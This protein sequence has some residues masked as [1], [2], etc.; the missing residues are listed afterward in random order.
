[1]NKLALLINASPGGSSGNCAHL[2]QLAAQH[3]QPTLRVQE[4]HL[5]AVK[6]MASLEPNLRQADCF[7]FVTGTYWDSWGSPLQRFLEELTPTE[8]SDLWLGK[9][10][11]VTVLMHSVGGKGVLSRLQGVLNTFGVMIPPMS[12]LVYSAVNH[13]VLN[14]ACK[15]SPVAQDLWCLEDL[16]VVCHNLTQATLGTNQWRAWPVDRKGFEK[17]WITPL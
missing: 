11:A 7:L 16:E 3:L 4:V 12:G 6:S 17:V 8:G 14:S 10:A 2:M 9:P 15:S 1:M 13:Q 5:A